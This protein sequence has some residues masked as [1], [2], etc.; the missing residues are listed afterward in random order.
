MLVVTYSS[1]HNHPSPVSKN[2]HHHHHNHNHNNN[3]SSSSAAAKPVI[4]KPEPELPVEPEEKFADELGWLGEMDAIATT[5]SAVLES[6]IFAGY[7]ADVAS[8]FMPM[9]EEDE[10]LFADL[11]ELPECSLVFRR[12]SL[13]TAEEWRRWCGTT[14]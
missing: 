9:G 5:S 4:N 1:D 7:D 12:G 11:G 3:H 10:S 14:S 13:E 8:V 6:P 2:H